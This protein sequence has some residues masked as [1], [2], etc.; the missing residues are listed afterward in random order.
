MAGSEFFLL[1]SQPFALKTV[2]QFNNPWKRIEMSR[3]I[4]LVYPSIPTTYWSY[5]YALPFVRKKA[6][7][8]PL[9]LLTVA[10]L[11]PDGY[12]LRLVDMNTSELKSADLE[13]ADLV[14]LSAM[15]VQ[16]QSFEKVVALCRQAGKTV[17][18]G[19]PY[20]TTSWEKIEGVD[21]F[22]LDEAEYTLPEF[23]RDLESGKPGPVYRD[24]RKPELALTPPPRFDL[25][26][27]MS[28]ESMPLQFS[29]GCPFNCEF[30]DIIELFGRKQRTK[31]PQQFLREVEELHATGFRGSLF[32]V[33][34]NFVGNRLKVKELLVP[35]ASWQREHGFP[36][37]LST[38]ASITLAQDNE[39][40]DL[41]VAAGFY[42][43]FIGIETPDACA[44][45]RAGKS[46]NLREDVL[47]S[48]I[49]IQEKGIEVSGGFIVGFDGESEDIF[50]RQRAFIQRSAISTAMVGLL[51]ALPNTRLHRRLERE[52]RILS[53]SLGNNTHN[54]DLNF[55]PHMPR[56]KLLSGYKWL[57]GQI[58]SARSYFQRSLTLIKRLPGRRAP[59]SPNQSAGRCGDSPP[60]G[61]METAAKQASAARTI[62]RKIRLAEIAAFLRSLFRQSFSSYGKHYLRFLI[63]VVRHDI[64]KI[65]RAVTLAVRGHHFVRITREMLKADAFAALIRDKLDVLGEVTA[66]NRIN[67]KVRLE[68]L[69]QRIR[70]LLRT[71]QIA[72]RELGQGVQNLVVDTFQ[73]FERRCQTALH[74]LRLSYG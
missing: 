42:M 11:L 35:L 1:F 3:K 38:E 23:L 9:G 31:D 13:W 12:E 69:E 6:L 7:L 52:G 30:C 36:F 2:I 39:L 25:I 17:V 55:V 65:P 40:L 58:Y 47:T 10:A 28:Y 71:A 20:P 57:L 26:D 48:V 29:R 21:H 14:F 74:R 63:Q 4:L 15:L 61:S 68:E 18:A 54:F 49:K 45:A 41:M 53:D 43:V 22:V 59:V 64:S 67:Q 66:A 56:E 5:K 70:G 8:P 51:I 24:E 73:D 50:E 62:P 72:Y 16:K 44:L 37:T 33:D 60:A 27:V 32:I 34:D 19:G 46:Q